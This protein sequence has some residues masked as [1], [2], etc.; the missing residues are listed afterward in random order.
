M[1]ALLVMHIEESLRFVWTGGGA[2]E[3]ENL[4]PFAHAGD[5]PVY[6]PL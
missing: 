2:G 3:A 6:S 4:R 1:S 5:N